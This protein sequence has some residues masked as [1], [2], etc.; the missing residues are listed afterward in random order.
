ATWIT[1]LIHTSSLFPYTTL[2]R[3][4]YANYTTIDSIAIDYPDYI[5]Y[6]G[7]Q[8]LDTREIPLLREDYVINEYVDSFISKIVIHLYTEHARSEEHTSELQSRFD[9]VCRL[10]LE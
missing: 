5:D 4:Y 6:T 3:S 1:H 9:L 8:I 2:F 10:L 7:T